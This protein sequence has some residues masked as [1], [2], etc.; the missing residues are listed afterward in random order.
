MDGGQVILGKSQHKILNNTL[1]IGTQTFA[2]DLTIKTVP[3]FYCYAFESDKQ[4]ENNN[5]KV[6]AND[7]H[8]HYERVEF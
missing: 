2:I 1:G 4:P 5:N 3:Q 8:Y 6:N 7:C